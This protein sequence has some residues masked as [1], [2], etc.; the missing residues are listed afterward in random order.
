MTQRPSR[1][2]GS[3]LVAALWL[4]SLLGLVGLS[5][6]SAARESARLTDRRWKTARRNQEAKKAVL[7]LESLWAASTASVT[8]AGELARWSAEAGEGVSIFDESSR[9]NLNTAS[10]DTLRRLLGSDTAA[11]GVGDWRDADDRPRFDGAE[12]TY[13]ASLGR[14]YPCHNGPLAAVEELLLIKGVTPALY[15]RVKE[16]VTVWGDGKINLN[17]VSSDTLRDLGFSA[18][19]AERVAAF[20]RGPDGRWGTVD[21]GVFRRRNEAPDFLPENELRRWN[22]LAPFLSVRGSAYRLD[23]PASAGVPRLR[24]VVTTDGK[25][26]GAWREGGGG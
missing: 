22:A 2:G 26:I 15:E 9:I 14:P 16:R 24:V 21:D 20:R 12:K 4:V 19:T 5:L 18:G 13:Y 10:T 8:T 3:V 23:F 11:A 25:G 6:S 17:T 1:N 7:L